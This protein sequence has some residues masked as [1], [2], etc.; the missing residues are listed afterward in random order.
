MNHDLYTTS[1]QLLKV[2]DQA[3]RKPRCCLTGHVDEDVH[4]TFGCVSPTATE[5]KIRT[6]P[7]PWRAATRRTSSRHC[8]TRSP[9]LIH[10]QLF[11]HL[12]EDGIAA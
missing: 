11:R 7:A 9:L 8:L 6:F 1:Q 10:P 12:Q 5:P 4:V 3:P 2:D